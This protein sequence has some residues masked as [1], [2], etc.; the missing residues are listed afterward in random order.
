MT[1]YTT[2][3]GSTNAKPVDLQRLRM[4]RAGGGDLVRYLTVLCMEKGLRLMYEVSFFSF[5]ILES[6]V[7]NR[8]LQQ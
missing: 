2:S 8:V 1:C 6:D 5:L 7:W 4:G 3:P